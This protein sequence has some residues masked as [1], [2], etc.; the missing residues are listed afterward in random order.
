MSIEIKEKAPQ[1]VALDELA[2]AVTSPEDEKIV[3]EWQAEL[4]AQRKEVL[5]GIGDTALPTL[6]E[7]PDGS[8]V[9]AKERQASVDAGNEPSGPYGGHGRA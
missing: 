2:T 3:A 4:D 7:L 6:I 5:T 1:Q 8:I 9:T